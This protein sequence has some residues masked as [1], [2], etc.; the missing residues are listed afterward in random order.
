MTLCVKSAFITNKLF[1]GQSSTAIRLMSAGYP[2]DEA[3]FSLP[4]F[5]VVGAS[6]EK[7]KF[8]NKVLRAYKVKGYNVTPI[9]K[10]VDAIEGISCEESLTSYA[11]NNPGT[12]EKTGVSIVT[13]PA[14]TKAVIEEGL[15]LGFRNFFLQPGT[16]DASVAPALDKARSQNARIIESC[17]LRQ[18]D[19]DPHHF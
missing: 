11:Q 8:G 5:V 10:K 15:S 4:S 13:P 6:I 14:A 12:A 9:N 1:R 3:F 18:L 16:V 7:A 17:V 2:K 19:L